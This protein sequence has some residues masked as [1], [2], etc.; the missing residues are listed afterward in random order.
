MADYQL[1]W[2]HL[3]LQVCVHYN[4]YRDLLIDGLTRFGSAHGVKLHPNNVLLLFRG[5]LTQMSEYDY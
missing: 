4:C 5:T 3:R 2:N 1:S